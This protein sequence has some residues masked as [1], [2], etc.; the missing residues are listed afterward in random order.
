MPRNILLV[1]DDPVVR[2]LVSEYLTAF[3]HQVHAVEGGRQCFEAL[4]EMRPDLVI[5]DYQMPEMSGIQVLERL[6]SSNDTKQIPVIMLSAN[7]MESEDLSKF[8]ADK[9]VMKPFQLQDF[10]AA[11]ESITVVESHD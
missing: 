10:L 5:V 8:K 9:Y 4:G 2:L 1:D 11:V 7:A 3:G 6:K